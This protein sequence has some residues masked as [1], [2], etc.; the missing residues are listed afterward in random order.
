MIGLIDMDNTGFPNLALM[1]IS[2]YYR[3]EGKNTGFTAP[4]FAGSCEQVYVSCVFKEN[5]EGRDALPSNTIYGGSGVSLDSSLPD[6]IEHTCPDYDLYKV[7]RSYGFLTRGCPRNCSWCIVPEKEG[8]IRKHADIHE[9]LR[10]DKVVL[11]DNNVLAHPWGIQQIEKMAQLRVAVDFNQGLDARLIDRQIARRLASLRWIRF[12]RLAC[13]SPQAKKWVGAAVSRLREAGLRTEIFC[14]VLV[15]DDIEDALDRVEFL[16][17]LNVDP[18][19]QP[20]RSLDGRERPNILQK[21]FARWVNHKAI[22][23]TV[24]FDDYLRRKKLDKT[25]QPAVY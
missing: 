23:K 3:Q 5:N 12:L 14:Y 2:A 17:S 8:P 1:K 24:L 9:F 20:Y 4:L 18:F 21:A 15:T 16:R 10:H 11:L 7:D 25:Q 19:A 22:F 6:T 13:D